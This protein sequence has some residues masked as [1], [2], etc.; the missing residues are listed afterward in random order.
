M[1]PIDIKTS[2]YLVF[3]VEFNYKYPKFKIDDHVK[4]F[5]REARLQVVRRSFCDQKS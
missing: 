4:T 5:L 1:K 3:G 2:R